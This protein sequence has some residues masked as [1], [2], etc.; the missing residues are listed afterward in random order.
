MATEGQ[1]DKITPD[2]ENVYTSYS[3]FSKKMQCSRNLTIGQNN[4]TG[5]MTFGATPEYVF[6][7]ILICEN[8]R[9]KNVS[10]YQLQKNC[11]AK[12]T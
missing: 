7:L 3:T 4:I 9:N 8:F 6:M 10:M 2:I 5:G 1:S 12:Q 11:L